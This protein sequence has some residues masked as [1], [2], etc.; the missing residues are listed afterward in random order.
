MHCL[1]HKFKTTKEAFQ[2]LFFEHRLCHPNEIEQL[3]VYESPNPNKAHT[4]C[5]ISIVFLCNDYADTF[6]MK[7]KRKQ[8]VN[9]FEIIPCAKRFYHLKKFYGCLNACVER[10]PLPKELNPPKERLQTDIIPRWR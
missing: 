8:W 10:R 2:F 9:D 4:K 3:K 1:K 6:Y 7:F 5:V